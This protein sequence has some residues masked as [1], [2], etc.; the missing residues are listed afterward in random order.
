MYASKE[1]AMNKTFLRRAS[2]LSFFFLVFSSQTALA[3]ESITVGDYELELG[4]AD[5]PPI[6]GQKNGVVI[7]VFDLSS[8]EALPVKDVSLLEVTISYGGQ[9]KAL[10]LQALGE[11][12]P[13]QYM[14]PI[15][16]AVPGEYTILLG[17]QLGDTAVD[18]EIHPE[19]VQP[20]EVL[21]FPRLEDSE[22]TVSSETTS[23]LTWLAILLG[24]AGAALGAS[25]HRRAR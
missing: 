23:W 15:L 10:L 20:A 2:I 7:S 18:A 19:E 12:S 3:H 24:F 11:D 17:G 21:Q 8:G 1:P 14:A 9:S 25:A 5:E 16:P 4:W 6:A 22:Q 13:G